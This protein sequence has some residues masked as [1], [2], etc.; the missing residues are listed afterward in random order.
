VGNLLNNARFSKGTQGLRSPGQASDLAG[1]NPA[2][3]TKKPQ[4][5]PEG[6]GPVKSSG[7][8]VSLSPC[9]DLSASR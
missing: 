4:V 9:P 5:I 3:A 7:R 6:A 8:P 1:S 2:P